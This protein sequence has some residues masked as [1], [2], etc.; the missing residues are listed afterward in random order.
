MN[1]PQH[2]SLDTTDA[3]G[4]VPAVGEASRARRVLRIVAVFALVV[5]FVVGSGILLVRDVLLPRVGEHREDIAAIASRALGLPVSIGAIDGDWSRL[6]PRLHLNDVV[7]SDAEGRP[8]LSLPRIDASFSWMSLLRLSPYFSRLE[9][10]S[11]TLAVRRDADGSLFVAGLRVGTEAGG[12]GT[13]DWL[14]RQGQIVIRDA[15]VSWDD[16]LRGAP[17]L[18]LQHLEFRLQRHFG[19]H[20]FALLAQPPAELAST[21]DLRGELRRL[22]ADEPLRAAGRLYL[23]LDRANLGGWRPWVDYPLPLQGEG[24]LRA[25]VDF[26][27]QPAT[28]PRAVSVTADVALNAVNTRLGERLP[29]LRLSHL[30]GRLS[31]S[32]RADGFDVGTRQLA[33]ETGDGLRVVPTDFSLQVRHAS[34]GRMLQ[35]NLRANR[36]DFAALAALAAY[37]PFDDAVRAGLAGFDPRGELS[38]LRLEWHG[39]AAAPESWSLAGDFARMG[40]A[41]RDGLPGLGGMSG[42]IEGN[43][44]GG[45]YRIDSRD[46]HVDLPQ[47]FESSMLSFAALRAEGGWQRHGGRLEISLD[48]ATFDN[49]DAAGTASGRYW[50]EP[51]GAGEIDMQARLTRAEG[52]S[53]WRYLPRVVNHDTQEWVRTAIRRAAVPDARLR[54]KGRLDDFPFRNGKGQFLVSVKVADGL[55]DYAPGWPVIDGIHGEVRFEG[56]GMRIEAPA[57]RMFDVKLLDVVA[58]VP[59]LDALPSEIMTIN[60]KASGTTADFLRFVAES[61]VSGHIDH[62]T[63]GMRAEGSGA[64]DLR[65]VMPLRK[66]ADTTVKGE[67]RFSGNRLWLVD[68]VP[69]LDAASGRVSFTEK[70]LAVPEVRAQALGEPMR[71]VARTEADGSVHFEAAGAVSVSAARAG[72]RQAEGWPVL[73]HLSGSTPWKA[74]IRVGRGGTRVLV[75]SELDGISTSLPAPFNKSANESWPL[76]VEFA[77]PPGDGALKLDV[78]L[79]DRVAAQLQRDAASDA[80]WRGGVGV[81]QQVRM[82]E[83]GVMVAA[84]FETLDVDAWRRVLAGAGEGAEAPPAAPAGPPPL[85]LAGVAL[86]A[87]EMRA[88]GQMLKGVQLRALPDE[89]G[90]RARLDSDL[91]AG[92]FDWRHAGDGTLNAHFRHLALAGE[93]EEHAKAAAAADET[94]PRSLPGLDVVA[95]RF[96]LRGK[97]LGRLEVVARNRGGL[98]QLER[99]SVANADGKLTGSGRWQAAGRQLTDLDFTLE[100]ADVG[101]FSRRLG[102]PDAVRGGQAILAGKLSWRGA[103]TRIDFPSLSGKMTL[104]AGSGQFNKLEP[105]V[106][107]LLGILSLQSLPRRI[108]LDFRDVFSSGF[109]FDRISGSID[110]ARGVLHTDDLEI[111]GPAARIHMRGAADIDAETQDIKVSVQP[112]LSESVAVGAAA[113]LVNPVA[114]VV[115]YVAQKVLSDPIEKFFSYE[116]TI[117]GTW[118]DPVVTKSGSVAGGAAATRDDGQPARK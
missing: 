37:L 59:D 99:L 85:A 43:E 97:D 39:D 82:A 112:T 104:E 14:L 7:V 26:G 116:Y 113:G 34:D 45:R 91:A 8:A 90:W 15:S 69:P 56:P 53:V 108:T 49:A 107:R 9:I 3:A 24:A 21:L 27:E 79:A 54:L 89:G 70:S 62:F 5:W 72:W 111:R 12:S 16:A 88:F 4:P 60:G 47:V 30:V 33:L 11:P 51:G 117:T 100:T 96:S 92:E 2:F 114:G 74:D 65:L 101:R 109:A 55:L 35:G 98:W 22:S 76:R 71:L 94:P 78:N 6:R 106:G 68:G 102:Y 67:Y 42:H 83:K 81:L 48:T 1:D 87:R 105:G 19:V 118:D 77:H 28:Q 95:D 66:V 73:D 20:R 23:S 44:R 52:T 13:L 29:E 93:G 63:D 86:Q 25:W 110:V 58:D 75:S 57:A 50:P 41:A 32:R 38:G 31:A 64:L 103:P 36:L 40:V 80:T 18:Q 46:A 61:P 84:E 17:G 115:A 10:R